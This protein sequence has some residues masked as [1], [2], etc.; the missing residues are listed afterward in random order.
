MIGTGGSPG[1]RDPHGSGS[2]RHGL[3]TAEVGEGH[4]AA[5]LWH[6]TAIVSWG[7]NAYPQCFEAPWHSHETRAAKSRSDDGL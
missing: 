3:F 4:V 6:C 5:S 1:T 2:N 7:W